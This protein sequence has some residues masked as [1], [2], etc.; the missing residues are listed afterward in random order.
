MMLKNWRARR[1]G[2]AITVY[3]DCAERN[4][5]A[6]ITRVDTITPGGTNKPYCIATGRDG[7]EHKLLTN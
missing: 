5:P 2:G 7:V 4:T 6:K 3:G 1:A